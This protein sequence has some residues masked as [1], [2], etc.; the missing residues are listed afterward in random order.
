MSN[1]E[2]LLSIKSYEEFDQNRD[3]F[4][5]ADF[6]DAEVIE[7]LNRLFPKSY[8]PKDMHREVRLL[9]EE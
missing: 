8:A 2:F 7:H 5:S 1:K 3:R 6:A 4:T 9:D